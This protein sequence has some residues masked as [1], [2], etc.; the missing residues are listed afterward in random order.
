MHVYACVHACMC[1]CACVCA[2]VSAHVHACA[3]GTAAADTSRRWRHSSVPLRTSIAWRR[4]GVIANAVSPWPCRPSRTNVRVIFFKKVDT[5]RLLSL[6]RCKLQRFRCSFLL[7]PSL[8]VLSDCSKSE[9]CH[10]ADLLVVPFGTT[11][12]AHTYGLRRRAAWNDARMLGGPARGR[13]HLS[14]AACSA[15]YWALLC[16]VRQRAIRKTLPRDD[17]I[18]KIHKVAG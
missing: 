2:R 14:R 8:D 11:L 15:P 1:A 5:C 7:Q 12:G 16:K 18:R 3:H 9:R 10:L 4:S 17:P 6:I 13:R